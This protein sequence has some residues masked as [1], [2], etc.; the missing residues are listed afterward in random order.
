MIS[1]THIFFHIWPKKL[2]TQCLD[3]HLACCLARLIY[4]HPWPAQLSDSNANR[5]A[6]LLWHDG[7][8]QQVSSWEHILSR[9]NTLI[10]CMCISERVCSLTWSVWPCLLSG[11][12]VHV[13]LHLS[14]YLP[15]TSNFTDAAEVPLMK[16]CVKKSNKHFFAA[17]KETLQRKRLK[18]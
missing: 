6:K 2:P 12:T 8:P 11:M 1:I 13:L 14:V 7:K 9:G 4:V 10:D 5:C 18:S 15:V 17:Q 3:F 16:T